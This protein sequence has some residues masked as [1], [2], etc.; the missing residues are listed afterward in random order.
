MEVTVEQQAEHDNE[1]GI[2]FD[3]VLRGYDRRQVDERLVFLR[4][5]LSAAEEGLR[6]SQQRTS[7][8]EG[9]LEQARTKLTQRSDTD[10]ENSF[11]FRVER[12]L[13]LAEAEA[14]QVRS[15]AD[16]EAAEVTRQANDDIE[17]R[18]QQAEQDLTTRIQA[19]ERD[20]SEREAAVSERERQVEASVSAARREADQL[21]ATARKEADVVRNDA[22]VET[23]QLRTNAHT[24]AETVLASA[25]AQAEKLIADADAAV[26]EREHA[27]EREL[28]RLTSLHDEVGGRLEATFKLLEAH[29][30][31]PNGSGP[32]PEPGQGNRPDEGTEPS[33]QREEGDAPAPDGASTAATTSAS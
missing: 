17:A 9:E 16:D 12:I 31:R 14:K 4:T 26:T 32:E 21:L 28:D 1:D 24:E 13:R 6:A 7:V 10:M 27:G 15:R 11:G 19:A 3:T 22:R 2:A 8:L 23:E 25:K 33:A 29:F 5:E 18:R 20:M 30:V